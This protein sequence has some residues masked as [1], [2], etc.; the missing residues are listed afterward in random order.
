MTSGSIKKLIFEY[1]LGISDEYLILTASHQLKLSESLN[2]DVCFKE[3]KTTSHEVDLKNNLI[4]IDIIIDRVDIEQIKSEYNLNVKQ[5]SNIRELGVRTAFPRNVKRKNLTI[6]L[7]IF[8][9]LINFKELKHTFERLRLL[10]FIN[11]DINKFK[12]EFF[13]SQGEGISAVSLELL[14]TNLEQV[15][16]ELDKDKKRIKELEVEITD[17]QNII[18]EAHALESSIGELRKSQDI[19]REKLNRLKLETSK[20]E[21]NIKTE[22]DLEVIEVNKMNEK[23]SNYKPVIDVPTWKNDPGKTERENVTTFITNLRHFSKLEIMV[24]NGLIF[25]SLNKSNKSHINDELNNKE[26]EELEEFISYLLKTYGGNDLT[27]RKELDSVKQRTDGSML[28][29]FDG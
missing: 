1:K 3:L 15:K 10:T 7:I 16:F 8:D 2:L 25:L 13:S 23:S 17:S 14:V 11:L 6:S 24:D 9:K 20:L 22:K 27:I 29:F 18:D 26:K 4:P 28:V 5:I 21:K 19:E 12:I